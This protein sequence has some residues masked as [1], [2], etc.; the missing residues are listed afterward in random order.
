MAPTIDVTCF[1]FPIFTLRCCMIGWFR[2]DAIMCS[3][4]H[5]HASS[6][7]RVSVCVCWGASVLLSSLFFP[8]F[9]GL[10]RFVRSALFSFSFLF[11]TKVPGILVQL[12]FS[13]YDVCCGE[14]GRRGGGGG[15]RGGG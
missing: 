2:C 6:F 12:L 4:A 10:F 11:F 15:W 3:C 5:V 13:P 14:I 1:F 8:F 7:F 9:R